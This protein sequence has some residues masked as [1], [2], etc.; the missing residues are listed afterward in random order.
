MQNVYRTEKDTDY[1]AVLPQ[2]KTSTP[3][4]FGPRNLSYGS[5]D[6]K[7]IDIGVDRGSPVTAMEGGTVTPSF[8]ILC[9][10]LLLL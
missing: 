4:K 3:S 9:M 6:H 8:L 7:G 2:G 5:N 10:D 1:S